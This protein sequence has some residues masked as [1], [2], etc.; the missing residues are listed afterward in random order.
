MGG[1][2][3]AFFTDNLNMKRGSERNCRERNDC[4]TV[5][6]NAAQGDQVEGEVNR[7]AAPRGL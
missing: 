7:V 4:S 5:D 3:E 2:E 6:E 1:G